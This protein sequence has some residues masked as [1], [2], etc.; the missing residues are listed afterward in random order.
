MESGSPGFTVWIIFQ[1]SA[2][3]VSAS[4]ALIGATIALSSYEE[5]VTV[6]LVNVTV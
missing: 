4:C 5:T 2:V 1:A 6:F 3:F